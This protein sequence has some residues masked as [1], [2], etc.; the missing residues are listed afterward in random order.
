MADQL[1]QVNEGSV[2]AIYHVMIGLAKQ[3]FLDS[4]TFKLFRDVYYYMFNPVH[5]VL[6]SQAV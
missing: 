3:D 1:S 6:F 4:K 2:G 5:Y